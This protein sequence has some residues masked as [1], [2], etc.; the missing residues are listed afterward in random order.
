MFAIS[1]LTKSSEPSCHEPNLIRV[2]RRRA[3]AGP[4]TRQ[5]AAVASLRPSS[6]LREVERIAVCS[7]HPGGHT[8]PPALRTHTEA[9]RVDR[10][11]VTAARRWRRGRNRRNLCPLRCPWPRRGSCSRRPGSCCARA[12]CW[13]GSGRRW[14]RP[15]LGA[16]AYCR[17]QAHCRG[18]LCIGTCAHPR[19]SNLRSV[20]WQSV[21]VRSVEE[22]AGISIRIQ[23]GLVIL[24]EQST[25]AT[26]LDP[27]WHR[28][29]RSSH[30]ARDQRL[31]STA[32]DNELPV[33]CSSSVLPRRT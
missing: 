14:R 23:H 13:R 3:A 24:W 31:W 19:A 20:L 33:R 7:R 15:R 6:H 1:A 29:P 11:V 8:T 27:Q 5:A 4:S 22:V 18:T 9:E 12:R 17:V 26:R 25:I 16:Q 28:D 2:R 32:S 21:T 30:S 10:R